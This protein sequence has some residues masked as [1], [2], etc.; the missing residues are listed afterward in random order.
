[1]VSKRK[2]IAMVVPKYGFVGG[3]EKFVSEL[4][5]RLADRPGCRIH[6]FANKWLASSKDIIFHKVPVI[7]FPKWLTTISFAFFFGLK[8]AKMDFDLVHGHDRI[9]NPDLVT[10]HSIPHHMWVKDIRQKHRFSLFDRGT[11]W[12][13]KQ[14]FSSK[15]CRRFL[16]VSQLVKEK[17]LEVFP[18]EEDKIRVIHPGVDVK[19]F[20]PGNLNNRLAIRQEFEIS[21]QDLLI[22]FVGMN[23]EVK[24][25]DQLL[26]AVARLKSVHHK[27]NVKVLVVGKGNQTKYQA[28]AGDL[29]I[30][31]Q[32]KFAGVRTDI[33]K[34]YQ[35]ADILVM[36]SKLDT[37]GM[38]VS[39]AMAT[40]LPV[41]VS[42]TVGAKDLIVQGGN[43]FVV[44]RE[45]VALIS[46]KIAF[47]FDKNNR[48]EMGR[49]AY[50]TAL[51]NTWAK[52][53]RKVS[54][55]YEEILG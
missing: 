25:L 20:Q 53:A 17:T 19:R 13:E 55:I 26:F 32:I 29:G 54:E 9:F 28:L 33:E 36:L 14:M 44:N 43:G 52:T 37:F 35:S 23:F 2:K 11:C 45:D 48:L 16:P 1:M 7:F 40:A 46:S 15:R 10:L 47:L 8:A 6:V 22:L 18:L 50:E 34:I 31:T 4:A 5:E 30:G 41:I 3:G 39:E 42:D 24:G 49:K 38:V 27:N 51:K 21:T 12:T